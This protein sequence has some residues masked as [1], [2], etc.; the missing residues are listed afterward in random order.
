MVLFASL[1][2]KGEPIFSDLE[3]TSSAD[4]SRYIQCSAASYVI[5]FTLLGEFL[6]RRARRKI[7]VVRGMQKILRS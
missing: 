5:R 1:E 4:A 2:F 3:D 6:S 7:K